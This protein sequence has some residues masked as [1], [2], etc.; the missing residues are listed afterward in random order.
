MKYRTKRI[1]KLFTVTHRPR[2]VDVTT[3]ENFCKNLLSANS[4]RSENL[5]FVGDLN[6]NALAEKSNKKVQHFLS[7]MFQYNMI[8]AA[9][10]PTRF[11]RNASA[12]ID[13]I[14]TSTVMCDIKSRFGIIKT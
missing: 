3:F 11:T 6:I 2:N 5:N 14:I 8:P 1:E 4:K 10:K 12:A 13:P 9:N 7:S